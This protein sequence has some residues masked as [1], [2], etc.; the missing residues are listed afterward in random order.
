MERDIMRERESI[1]G[2]VVVDF[3]YGK[4]RIF[5][6]QWWHE[7]D[8]SVEYHCNYIHGRGLQHHVHLQRSMH[9]L[10]SHQD[11]VI[12]FSDGKTRAVGGQRLTTTH[13]NVV[14][15]EEEE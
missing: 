8:L 7:H 12:F 14:G 13:C 4:V 1:V 3:G 15:G 2:T 6:L 9:G 10:L 5:P 11:L